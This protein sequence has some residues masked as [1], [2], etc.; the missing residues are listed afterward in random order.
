MNCPKC[1]AEISI[2]ADF[3]PDCGEEIEPPAQSQ[4][5]IVVS[6]HVETVEDGQVR[7]VE[8]GAVT[9]DVF[10]EA[11]EATRARRHRERRNGRIL[12]D[13]V[14]ESWVKG[15][16]E[17]SLFRGMRI[18]LDKVHVPEAI[19]HPWEEVL[20]LSDEP[21]PAV[22]AGKKPLDIHVKAGDS[23]LILGA[24]GSGKTI[25]LLEL[26]RDAIA[27]AERDPDSEIPVVF[28]LSSWSAPQ[29]LAD[30]LA[31]ELSTK[32]SVPTRIGR[33]WIENDDLILL[34]DGLDELRPEQRRACVA[35]INA[36]RR[37]HGTAG[38]VICSRAAEYQALDTRLN[39]SAAIMIQ[40]LSAAQAHRYLSEA[41]TQ[42]AG[43]ARAV[44]QDAA[45][46]EMAQTP[47]MLSVM[48]NAYQD[49][50]T[51]ILEIG[52]QDSMAGQLKQLFDLYAAGMFR[53]KGRSR[54]FPPEQTVR[55]LS[56]LA[57]GME[58]HDQAVFLV[59][60]LQPSW[61]K[62]AGQ[63]WA[64][65][66]SSRSL[67]G[68]L[69]GIAP[70]LA[71]GAMDMDLGSAA[72][73]L[74]TGLLAGVLAGLIS[75]LALRGGSVQAP[76]PR[77]WRRATNAILMGLVIVLVLTPMD[78]L[79]F[80]ALMPDLEFSDQLVGGLV[81]GLLGGSSMGLIFGLRTE[82]R[83]AK[84]DI[85]PMESLA[86]SWRGAAVGAGSV[87]SLAILA[88]L[89]VIAASEL[90][91]SVNLAQ[92]IEGIITDTF[93]G[94]RVVGLFFAVLG[95]AVGGLRGRR[96]QATT[97][98]NQG[99]RESARSALVVGLSVVLGGCAAFLLGE[100]RWGTS[101]QT[102]F[103]S[104]IMI[105][106]MLLPAGVLLGGG[107][108]VIQH[109]ILRRLLA[110]QSYLPWNLPRF[111]DHCADL[112]FLRKVGGGYIFVHRLLLEYFTDAGDLLGNRSWP[113]GQGGTR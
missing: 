40:P 35:A 101:L 96:L 113:I 53:R 39:V 57:Q 11:G 22:V 75:G 12:L 27:R 20:Q 77:P 48:S 23:L 66:L 89:L 32:Y 5:T 99:I 17:R 16:L 50:G 85:Q 74:T 49:A 70:A 10:I 60:E 98:V 97:S 88:M 64:Y 37:E 82:F 47:L 26:A 84:R 59:E 2:P 63:R 46:L 44:E 61:L 33:P 95:G 107:L 92:E 72:I 28:N 9:G 81:A 87:T 79:L 62:T 45:L 111:L 3:C 67:A 4:T 102:S 13:R 15:V 29:S 103:E 31:D 41:G 34:L 58:V 42:L 109:A 69:C 6:Q 73:L 36:F 76:P 104:A 1:H 8:I 43:L 105:G 30:W 90:S 25:T 71:I 80:R 38:I 19:E 56:R 94:I 78:F 65:M 52:R 18:D 21:V 110:R 83:N 55:W 93:E 108:A 68:L 112:V 24:P 51:E 54:P 106:A 14:K 86:W 7:G 91:A 100:L